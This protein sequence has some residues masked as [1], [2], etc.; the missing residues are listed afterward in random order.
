MSNKSQFKQLKKLWGLEENT[1][2]DELLTH[3]RRRLKA[4]PENPELSFNIAEILRHQEN[5]AEAKKFYKTAIQQTDARTDARLTAL[6]KRLQQQRD[7]TR[8][9][10][11]LFTLIPLILSAL[12]GLFSWNK[13]NQPEVLPVDSDPEK[14]AF[15]Q[16]LAKQ[17]MAEVMATLKEQNPELSFDFSTSSANAQSPMEFMQSLM[18]PD[19][20]EE[21]RQNQQASN[22]QQSNE[23]QGR[24]A[25]Q[26]SKE[27]AV[28]CSAKDIPNASGESRE[29]VMLLMNAYNSILSNE[30]DCSKIVQSIEAIGEKL[31]WRKSERRI[32]AN[33][34][35]LAVECFYNSRNLEKTI[36]HARKL[37][38]AGD[39]S[40]INGV[41]WYMTAINHQKG[42]KSEAL[43]SYQCF[44]E[45][46]DYI[47]EYDF[48]PAYVASRYRESGALAWLYFDDIDTATSSLLKGRDLLK[49][50]KVKS[51][52]IL[53]VIS[54]INLDLMETYVT[55][56]ID[57]PAFDEL[58]QEINSSGLLTDG[59]KQIKDALAAVY[60]MQNGNN[61]EAI[62]SLKNISSRFSQ[63]P[64][65]ICGWNWNGFVRGLDE[66][67]PSQSIREQ[68]KN[69]VNAADCYTPQTMEARIQQIN[70]ISQWLR[71]K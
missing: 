4:D 56:N 8:N 27:P 49:N 54:E 58:L 50:V 22:N 38:C 17:Q 7:N 29:E 23:G 2:L 53:Q 16:W 20:I 69:L 64:E 21:M 28:M 51:N 46:T 35:D 18:K 47:S 42:N 65:F 26:C 25:F 62:V 19:A 12:I 34:E 59:Y 48:S 57:K 3:A 71:S 68:A 31:Q 24:P 15:T 13:L 45:A 32:K 63:M 14:F 33:L 1:P 43:T 60:N 52:S 36:E 70:R 5:N 6:E 41:Y 61:E 55:A 40:Y 44:Q 66:S 10:L 9:K 67:I 37:Q 11:L 30:K 39:E